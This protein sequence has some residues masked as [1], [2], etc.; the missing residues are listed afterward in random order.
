VYDK[1]LKPRQSFRIT[2][3]LNIYIRL[4][5]IVKSV[6]IFLNETLFPH[7]YLLPLTFYCFISKNYSVCNADIGDVGTTW[8]WKHQ[9]SY[10]MRNER[11]EILES[12]DTHLSHVCRDSDSLRPRQSA[13]RM[14]VGLRS[15]RIGHGTHPVSCTVGA[16]SV[17]R[18]QSGCGVAFTTHPI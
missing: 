6:I 13:N 11:S 9:F 14:P 5:E 17:S 12:T 15:V 18:G 10:A 7:W 8:L 1:L 16:A 3:Y 2:L 4:D